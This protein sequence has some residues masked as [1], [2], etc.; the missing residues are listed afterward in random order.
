MVQINEGIAGFSFFRAGARRVCLVGDFNDWRPDQLVMTADA[1]GYWRACL[2][3]SPGI[4]AFRYFA[5]GQWCTDHGAFGI[6]PG[7]H[8]HNSVLRV[9]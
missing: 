6:R 9:G 2:M 4:H 1:D 8:G 3:L 7:P 5:D